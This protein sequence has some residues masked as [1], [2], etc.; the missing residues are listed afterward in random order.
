MRSP[1]VF[2][3]T[4]YRHLHAHTAIARNAGEFLSVPVAELG[5][6]PCCLY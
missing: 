1:A 3:Q 2:L 4:V 6:T 5:E